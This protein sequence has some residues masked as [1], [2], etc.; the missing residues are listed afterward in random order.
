MLSTD[1]PSSRPVVGRGQSFAGTTWTGNQRPDS[2]S[3]RF[4]SR[5]GRKLKRHTSK[6]SLSSMNRDA[7]DVEE[8]KGWRNYTGDLEAYP[9]SKTWTSPRDDK[10]FISEPFNFQHITHTSPQ[11]FSGLERT[12][13]N[14]LVSDFSAARAAQVP[15]PELRGIKA[16]DLHFRNF[17]SDALNGLGTSSRIGSTTTL[18]SPVSLSPKTSRYTLTRAASSNV[19]PPP[20]PARQRPSNPAK[21]SPPMSPISPNTIVLPPR[22]SSRAAVTLTYDVVSPIQPPSCTSA[23]AVVPSRP[24]RPRLDIEPPEASSPL[25]PPMAPSTWEEGVSP[26]SSEVAHAVTTPD[27]TAW[28]MRTPGPGS[29]AAELADVPEEEDLDLPKRSSDGGYRPSS[30]GSSL[31]QTKSV[32]DLMGFV[33]PK[34]LRGSWR[35]SSGIRPSL[36][37]L[38]RGSEPG[39]ARR[40]PL[41]TDGH[42]VTPGSA[43]RLSIGLRAVEGCWEDDIDYCYE[44]A[45]EADCEYAWE[46]HSDEG[47][48]SE[49]EAGDEGLSMRDSKQDVDREM[50][51]LEEAEDVTKAVLQD[52]EAYV[53]RPLPD[54][55]QIR[56]AVRPS[57]VVQSLPTVPDLDC[58]PAKSAS[59]TESEIVTPL[60]STVLKAPGKGY[61]NV[62]SSSFAA[63]NGLG[64]DP[65]LF[66]SPSFPAGLG[67]NGSYEDLVVQVNPETRLSLYD[68]SV[69]TTE[70]A[71]ESFRSSGTPLS[72]CNSQ[73]SMG[74]SRVPSRVWQHQSTSSTGSVPELVP[75]HGGEAALA[76]VPDQLSTDMAELSVSPHAMTTE[77]RVESYCGPQDS[78]PRTTRRASHTKPVKRNHGTDFSHAVASKGHRER[79][80]SDAAI[81]MLSGA[82]ATEAP[83][84]HR[85]RSASSAGSMA[86]RRPSTDS[87]VL[88][89]SQAR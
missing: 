66:I 40:S 48:S 1:H 36:L 5:N 7:R 23:A 78:L 26:L 13:P 19:D 65:A 72:K 16:D 46:C 41:V 22:K 89:P 44:H 6:L 31:R 59:T 14:E 15:Q 63:S 8:C 56:P 82:S 54:R 58:S 80:H 17:S 83:R 9:C 70:S 11:Q 86:S 2:P 60:Q 62:F 42:T 68:S 35:R 85:M 18:S 69:E 50:E 81:K 3:K 10:P 75:S 12:T 57:L 77:T 33:G 25:S 79:S 34:V 47:S 4:F 74:A 39:T 53:N 43:K 29:P 37:V 61:Q 52:H 24:M 64:L 27:D 49:I 76:G 67:Q 30:A 88:F 21:S 55:R 73:E 51:R 84:R 32:P 87:Y 20:S 71:P 28:P 38:P 45:A